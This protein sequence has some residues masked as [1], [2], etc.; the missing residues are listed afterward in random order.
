MSAILFD[1][2]DDKH[3]LMI[4]NANWRATVDV[5]R[6]FGILDAERL[7]RLQTAWLGERVTEE[8][9]MA[10]GNAL[11]AGPLST[12]NWSS[13]V[14]PPSRYFRDARGD[15]RDYDKDTQWPAWLRA[16]AEFCLTCKGFEVC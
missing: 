8:E 3:D 11:V 12:V 14:F 4:N 16:L 13:K 9:A 15:H 7:Q 1:L 6:T 5:L 10:I 2:G